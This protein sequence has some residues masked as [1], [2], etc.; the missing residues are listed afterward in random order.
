MRDT[1]IHVPVY[2]QRCEVRVDK[3]FFESVK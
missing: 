2:Y 1:E 3:S